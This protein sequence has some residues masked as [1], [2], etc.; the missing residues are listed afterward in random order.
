MTGLNIVALHILWICNLNWSS[1]D[2]YYYLIKANFHFRLAKSEYR[3]GG[4][5]KSGHKI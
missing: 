2:V 4:C 5:F 1:Y 3:L